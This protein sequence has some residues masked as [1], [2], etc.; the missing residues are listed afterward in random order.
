MDSSALIQA[1]VFSVAVIAAAVWLKSSLVKQRHEELEGL[2]ET[3]GER[4]TDLENEVKRLAGEI[5]SLKGQMLAI[6]SL[7]VREIADQVVAQILPF[8][9]QQG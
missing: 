6:Q 4:V 8:M 7:K 2:A 9:T 3:R 5:E 1:I